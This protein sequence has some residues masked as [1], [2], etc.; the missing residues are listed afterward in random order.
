MMQNK[1]MWERLRFIR[2][3][4]EENLSQSTERWFFSPALYAQYR[5]V[6]PL[7]EDYVRGQVIDLGCGVMPF[8]ELLARMGV[9]YHSLDLWPRSGEVTYVGD[10]QD[11]PMVPTAGYDAAICLE[12]LEHVPQP[13]RAICE[14]YRILKPGGIFILSVPHLS[15]LH[16]E[17]HDYYRFTIHGIRYLLHEYGFEILEIKVKG[18]LISFL[19]HQISTILLSLVWPICG[20]RQIVW[21]LNKWFVTRLFYMIDQRFGIKEL[22][23]LGYV[24]AARKPNR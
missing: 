3:R 20:A 23:P 13:F 19:G 2:R 10:I 15:R 4:I 24:I 14:I 5:A 6:V 7:I 1:G 12:V 21:F 17:P 9:V 8:R 16:D 22:F 11:M 18:G